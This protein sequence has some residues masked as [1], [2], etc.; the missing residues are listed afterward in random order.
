M[1]KVYILLLLIFAGFAGLYSQTASQNYILIH[2][3]TNDSCTTFLDKIQYFDGL[4]RPTETVQKGITPA[5]ADLVMLQEYDGFGRDSAA[6]LPAVVTGNNGAYVA[7]ATVRTNAVSSNGSDAKPY[8][9]PVYEASPLNR[10]LQQFGVGADWQ[11][12]GKSVKTEYLTNSGTSGQQSCALFSVSGTGVS[13]KV[14]RNNFYPDAQLYVTKTTDEEGNISYQFKDKLD[15]VVLTRQILNGGNVD[16]Y[17]VYDDFGNLCF[18]VPPILADLSVNGTYDETTAQIKQYAYIYRYDGRNRC[19]F[20]KF[21]GCEP[22]YYVY[23]KADRL[24]FTQDGENRKK[25]EWQF[26]IPDALG[27]VVLTGICKDTISVSNKLVK[28]V[29]STAGTYKFYTIQ[30]DGVTKTFINTPTILSEN[31]YDGYDFLGYNGVPNDVNNTQY[32]TETGYDACYGD[33]QAANKWKSKGLLTGTLTAQINPDGT[34]SST[35]LYSVMY[36]DYRGRLVQSKGN[37]ALTDGLEKEYFA[38]DFMNN[39]TRKMHIHTAMNKT[40]QNEVYS[41]TYDHAGRLTKETHQLNGGTLVN[42]AENTYDEL[43]RLK[44]NKKGSQ[45]NLNTTYA[46]NIR[47]WLRL[48]SSSFFTESLY[49]KKNGNIS[50]MYWQHSGDPYQRSYAFSYDNL[51]RLTDAKYQEYNTADNYNTT[52]YSYD[53]QG[54]IL[55]LKRYGQIVADDSYRTQISLI[56]NL[57]FSYTDTGNQLRKVED[58]IPNILFAASADFKNY[59]NVATEYSY[60]ANGAL[61]QDLNKGIS[62]IQYNSLN[63]P[64]LMDIKSPVAE[65]RNEYTYSAAGQKLK[66]V[67]KWNPS[68]STT[69]VGGV[70]SPI[71]TSS[72]TSSKKTEYIGNMIYE[73]DALKWILVDGG[74]IYYGTYYYYLT[75]HQGNNRILS[76]GAT[77]TQTNHYYP[78][79]M[80]FAETSTSQQG[81]QPYKYNGKELDMMS[82]LNQYDYGARYYDPA[83]G[84]FIMLDPLCEK[85]YSISPYAYA[86]NNPVRLVDPDGKTPRIYVEMEGLGH[87]FVTTGT[88]KNTTVYTYGRYGELD[89]NKSSARELSRTGEGVLIIMT[90][91]EALN[92]IAG[93]VKNEGAVIYEVKNGSDEK[94]DT[95]FNYMFNSSDQKPSGEGKYANA[96]NARVVDTYDLLDNNCTT[97]T[98]EAV[99]IST[100]GKLDLN[101]KNPMNVDTKLYYENQK[102]DSQ[103]KQIYLKDIIDEYKKDNR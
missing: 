44:T 46:Y 23:D 72:L 50:E 1:K 68:Y 2:T 5:K 98:V 15:R 64:R 16:T 56:D 70:S 81:F 91:A 58:S 96:N 95:H 97:K 88:G 92:Y 83:L 55:K 93:K 99:K 30:V 74:Y 80:V 82:G 52:S 9:Y 73:N 85:Y 17:Y 47:S 42:L 21:P 6:W 53:K 67:Q 49:F 28:G 10:V 26:S 57:T 8:S 87:T 20:K 41:Y 75:D 69:P 61:T 33:H 60:N 40:A 22:I 37:N 103:V 90:G 79:G 51:S 89:A 19:I 11:N 66:V 54:N 101:S 94:I 63:L 14:N 48:I 62:D 65:A 38:Y 43:G 76:A 31:I 34:V 102:K 3:C 7:P 71:N 27:R 84:R 59:S 13:T 45:V 25:S 100:D 36:Y 4:G 35:Y 29:F 78:F 77:V 32:K 86:L 18:V 39:P 24:I 12:N